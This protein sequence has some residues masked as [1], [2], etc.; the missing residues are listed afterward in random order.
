MY[1]AKK[2]RDLTGNVAGDDAVNSD[3][4]NDD[5]WHATAGDDAEVAVA[6]G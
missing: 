4:I 5:G 6:G 2:R 1:Y 3:G